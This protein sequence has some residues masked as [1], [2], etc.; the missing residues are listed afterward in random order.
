MKRILIVDDS[1]IV[2]EAARH[3][4]AHAGFE[5]EARNAV[6]EPRGFDLILMDVQMPD[7]YG[8]EIAKDLRRDLATPIYLFSTLPAEELALR[9]KAAAADG[10]ISKQQGLDHLVAEVR[11]SRG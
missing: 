1:P 11:R 10:F 6:G 5:V 2:L 9:A 3:V 4:L 7:R 8:D